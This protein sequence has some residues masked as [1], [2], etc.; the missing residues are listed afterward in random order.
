[1]S[2]APR[3]DELAARAWDIH[4]R[5]EAESLR[6]L[7][8]PS[9]PILFFGDSDRY[10]SS[11]VRVLTVGLNPSGRSFRL[12]THFCAFEERRS[13]NVTVR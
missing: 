2:D 1:M 5:A 8:R 13:C 11:P 4:G 7:V 3:L 12:P 10:L 6:H 9:V